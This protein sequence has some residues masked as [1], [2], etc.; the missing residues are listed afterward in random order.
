MP[1]PPLRAKLFFL[2]FFRL[3]VPITNFFSFLI[4]IYTSS[5]DVSVYFDSD[6]KRFFQVFEICRHFVPPFALISSRLDW[7]RDVGSRT[8]IPLKPSDLVVSFSI[9]EN[10]PWKMPESCVAARC[11]RSL[12]LRRIYRCIRFRSL[13]RNAG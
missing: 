13:A 12:T 10:I 7:S 11:K 3:K 6:Q 2:F 8:L 1:D 4:Q 9:M 5:N